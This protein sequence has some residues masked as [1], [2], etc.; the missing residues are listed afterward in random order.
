MASN[1]PRRGRG[2]RAVQLLRTRGYN[3]QHEKHFI[4]TLLLFPVTV[5]AAPPQ[6][7]PTSAGVLKITPIQ[8]ASMMI[9]AE[10]RV[11]YIDPSQGIYAGLLPADRI[12]ITDSRGDHMAPG[13]VDKLKKSSAE[14]WPS[15]CRGQGHG[16]RG[17]A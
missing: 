14:I 5:L 11:L 1:G 17:F 4:C 13:V 12:L 16:H 15:G 8:Y 3:L 10:G 9:E 7:F 2:Y 6:E